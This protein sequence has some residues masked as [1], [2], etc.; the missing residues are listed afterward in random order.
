[1][2]T[3]VAAGR[4]FDYSHAVGGLEMPQPIASSC[5]AGDTVYVLN[6][7]FEE[8]LD[9]PWNKA[10][11]C[12]EVCS[13]TMPTTPGA[14]V[15]LGTFSKYGDGDGELIWPVSIALDSE[16]NIYIADEWMNRISIFTNTGNFLRHWGVSGCGDGEFNRPSGIVLDFDDVVYAV[17]GM[18]HRVQKLSKD[19]QYISQFGSFG[20]GYGEFNAPWG[21][22]LDR[23]G[24]VYVADHKNHRVQKFDSD[25]NYLM[26]FGSYG[27][28]RGQLNRPS[29]VA[30]DPDGDVYVCDWGNDRVQVFA[31]DGK[32]IASLIGDAQQMARGHQEQ[33]DAN[34]DVIK[35]RRRAYSLEP[36]WRFA[37]P[38]GVT[39]DAANSRLIVADTQRSR[40]QIYNKVDDYMEAQ[41]NL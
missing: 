22:A 10:A 12:V 28:G 19:S 9:V 14:E 38:T 32:F 30:V 26:S 41:F 17:D 6:R 23:E 33:V 16:E 39:F 1:M 34:P 13:F 2:L 4:V 31:P 37:M 5:G 27:K 18:N 24:C 40:V 35:A 29:D 20:D 21:I 25:G 7:Q 8:I 3:T 36:E 15:Y 11:T